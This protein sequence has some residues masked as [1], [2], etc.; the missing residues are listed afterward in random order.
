MINIEHGIGYWGYRTLKIS[1]VGT[2]PAIGRGDGLDN[3]QFGLEVLGQTDEGVPF[4][5]VVP[6]VY[7]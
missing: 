6:T 3:G 2:R 5:D 4:G 1:G 7:S